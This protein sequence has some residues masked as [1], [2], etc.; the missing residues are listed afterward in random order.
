[1][2]ET[3]GI[4]AQTR[5]EICC[6]L[7]HA[8]PQMHAMKH[9][10]IVG[11]CDTKG[12]ELEYLR[13]LISAAG[14][15][16]MLIDVGTGTPGVRADV[17]T[18]QVAGCHPQGAN[19]VLGGDDRGSAV[20]A[21]GEAFARFIE[22]RDDI[23][24]IIGVGG[25]GGTSIVTAG[26]RRLPIGLPK[27]M[28]STLA[29]GDVGPYVGPTDITMMYSVTDIAGLNSISR[30]VLANAAHAIAGMVSHT[31]A[32]V[33]DKPAVGLTMFGVTTT[34]VTA[35]ADALGEDL[36]C[37]IFHAT[38]SGGQAMEK[39]VDSGLLK[40]VIDVTTTEVCDHLFDGVLSAGPGR[41]DAIAR[42]GIPYIGSV[43]AL[44]MV[45]F[46]AMDTVPA[47]L[48]GRNLYAHNPQVTLM[49]TSADECRQIG[50][51]IADKLN[52]CEGP[53]RFLI[54]EKGVSALDAPG[55][56]FYDPQADNALFEALETTLR[57]TD[58]R[59]L[60]RLPMHINDPAFVDALVANFREVAN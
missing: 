15:D 14:G 22:S 7:Q 2:E 17:P 10:F 4:C 32:P 23:A 28:V 37:L 60:I 13:H 42:T 54:P 24:G 36:D 58:K 59:R 45:N 19:A 46:W 29:S 30:K 26:M 53:V 31:V 18:A 12:A 35:V 8:A 40:A 38:G 49:R 41:L 27:L 43:G 55:K 16:V 56:P 44:D 20:A 47:A 6:A 25:G 52:A 5:V 21:M 1:M 50:R 11:T 34:C 9:I 39:L 57:P 33:E 48:R 3:Y 51:W